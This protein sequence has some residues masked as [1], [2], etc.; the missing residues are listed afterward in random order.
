VR[1]VYSNKTILV[2]EVL[3][4]ISGQECCYRFIGQ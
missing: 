3:R 2:G 1:K 4:K